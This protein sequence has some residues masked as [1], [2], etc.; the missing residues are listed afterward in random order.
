MVEKLSGYD[1]I[2][3][4][5]YHGNKVLHQMEFELLKMFHSKHKNLIVSLEMFERDV[6]PV[7]DN[8]LISIK[9]IG[10]QQEAKNFKKNYIM[11]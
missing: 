11:R 5:E 8:Y 4:G 6:Q 1:M 2:F 7:L 3:F 10:I 9:V